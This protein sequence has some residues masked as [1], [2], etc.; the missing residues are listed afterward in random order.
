MKKLFVVLLIATMIVILAACGSEASST[1]QGADT[2]TSAITTP[3]T[4]TAEVTT[5]TTPATTKSDPPETTLPGIDILYGDEADRAIDPDWNA[6]YSI[7]FE[8][9]HARFQYNWALV[10]KMVTCDNHI[11]SDI[12]WTVSNE[13]VDDEGYAG[14]LN[15]AY[16]FVVTF[17]GQDIEIERFSIYHQGGEGYIR[18]DLGDDFSFPDNLEEKGGFDVWLR[19]CDVR[20]EEVVY[21]YAWFTDPR[22]DGLYQFPPAPPPSYIPFYAG[23]TS[24]NATPVSGPEGYENLFDMNGETKLLTS[25]LATPIVWKYEE[26]VKAFGYVFVGTGDDA[27]HPERVPTGWKL[28]G[29]NDGIDWK[30]IGGHHLQA[31]E[32]A[33]NYDSRYF[34]ASNSAGAYTYFKLGFDAPSEYQLSEIAIYQEFQ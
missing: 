30:M 18:M 26:P 17:E 14:V 10:V 7:S 11:Y 34:D 24:P 4:T 21:Y 20:N 6:G 32:A 12:V 3:V 29:S 15:P 33:G 27:L 31:L 2:T 19:I 8:N 16:R 25:D 23:L 1:T 28:Y 9:H 13:D 22:Y 5:I